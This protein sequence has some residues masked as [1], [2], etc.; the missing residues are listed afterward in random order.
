MKLKKSADFLASR[1]FALILLGALILLSVTGMIIPQDTPVNQQAYT[2]W[3]AAYP[4]LSR[5]ANKETDTEKICTILRLNGYLSV[6]INRDEGTIRATKY[7]IGY[8]GPVILHLG[9]VI[10]IVGALLSGL[11]KMEG[12]VYLDLYFEKYFHYS[13]WVF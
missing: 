2:T 11:T 4:E 1:K 6:N 5:I 7:T 3:S 12:Y 10:I 8:W 13:L 9:F